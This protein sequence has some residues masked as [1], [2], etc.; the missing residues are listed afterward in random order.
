[1]ILAPAQQ[2]SVVTTINPARQPM[3]QTA[4]SGRS[5][6]FC[7]S[8]AICVAVRRGLAGSQALSIL[9]PPR[10]VSLQSKVPGLRRGC[11][12]HGVN[13]ASPANRHRSA[14]LLILH[15]AV[16]QSSPQ[17]G[18]FFSPPLPPPP[19]TPTKF[20]LSSI[21]LKLMDGSVQPNFWQGRGRLHQAAAMSQSGYSPLPFGEYWVSECRS[22]SFILCS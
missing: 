1:M 20:S 13:R 15:I 2:R 5:P 19:P 3:A 18:F 11:Q 21:K 16:S 4:R 22:E 8:T 9:L 12:D 7:S 6:F 10:K 17:A 14:E